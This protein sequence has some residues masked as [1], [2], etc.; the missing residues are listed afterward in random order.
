MK[1]LQL[2]A[3][4]VISIVATNFMYAA[5]LKITN[6]STVSILAQITTSVGSKNATLSP[7]GA[8]TFDSGLRD[9]AK[10]KWTDRG[11]NYSVQ[12]NMPA[13]KVLGTF[14]IYDYGVYDSSKLGNTRMA[15]F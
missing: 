15:D 12:L 14:V 4:I 5:T 6:K 13:L 1:Q 7:G 2:I 9:I 11:T 3:F 10:V 8:K